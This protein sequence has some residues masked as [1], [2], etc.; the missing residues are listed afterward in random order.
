[1][2]VFPEP[3][4]CADDAGRRV[5]GASAR[6]GQYGDE[7][8]AWPPRAGR[9]RGRRS[10][11][12][13]D[14]RRRLA[15]ALLAGLIAGASL[16]E[17]A[18]APAAQAHE[19]IDAGPLAARTLA[20]LPTPENPAIWDGLPV[21]DQEPSTPMLIAGDLAAL[22]R[23]TQEAGA[24]A[25][26]FGARSV[27]RR[28]VDTI[29]KAS[30]EAG[31]DPVYMMALADTESGFDTGAKAAT[32]SA[33][34]LFQFVTATWLEMIRDHGARYGLG[35]EAAS[36]MGRRGAITVSGAMRGRVLAL[37]DDPRV[38]ALMAAELVK[39]ERGRVEAKIGRALSTA[40]LYVAHVFGSAGAGRFLSL[41]SENPEA[42]AERAFR[43][44]ARANHSLFTRKAGGDRHSL[45]VAELH[46]RI[47]GMID[48]RLN[49]YQGVAALA[50]APG[51]VPVPADA[52][53]GNRR[54]KVTQAS[55]PDGV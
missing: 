17:T 36:V 33:R 19:R 55:P 11:R 45:T 46:G 40:E 35:E 3:A 50:G 28:L 25:V 14:A 6:A 42:V 52:T 54:V 10:H 30:E 27:A 34:G 51:G 47:G 39:R 5:P 44:A 22:P 41:S 4:R 15:A 18:F 24:D 37:R 32:S 16:P 38:A 29:L 12:R 53:T 7:P 2:G 21:A 43:R 49:R 9:G 1:M 31:V 23:I 26:R 8:A 48:R 20:G 13:T